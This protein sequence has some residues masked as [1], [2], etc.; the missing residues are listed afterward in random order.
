MS[1]LGSRRQCSSPGL[2]AHRRG[3]I[4]QHHDF[5]WGVGRC[6]AEVAPPFPHAVFGLPG[7]DFSTACQPLRQCPSHRDLPPYRAPVWASSTGVPPACLVPKSSVCTCTALFIS[8]WLP[9]DCGRWAPGH[10]LWREPNASQ[11]ACFWRIRCVV[12]CFSRKEE[13]PLPPGRSGPDLVARLLELEAFASAFESLGSSTSSDPLG[14]FLAK[15]PFDLA[16]PLFS[17]RLALAWARA[18]L[19]APPLCTDLWTTFACVLLTVPSFAWTFWPFDSSLG[20]PGEGWVSFRVWGWVWGFCL[21]TRAMA[22][23]APKTP[24]D[25]RRAETRAPLQ[26]FADRVVRP[27][28]RANREKL[29]E[30]FERWLL[31]HGRATVKTMLQWPLD[32]TEEI[33]YILVEYGRS[34][35]RTGAAYYRYSETINAIASARPGI[36]RHLGAAWDPAF[37]WLSE[38]PHAH[39]RALPKGALLALLAA[40]LTWGWLREAAIFGLAWAG[41]LRIGEALG[42]RRRDLILPRDATPGTDYALLQIATPKTRG[43][44][45]KHQAAPL[46]PPDIIRLLDIAFGELPRGAKL[47]PL[48]PSDAASRPSR[49]GL[50]CAPLAAEH[51]STWP[52]SDR[53]E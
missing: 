27:T 33:S 53:E 36:R 34:L 28:T 9:H 4:L 41:L 25:A 1:Y 47:W 46:D 37:P 3:K 26:L 6:L 12:A 49:R 42:A 23:A 32:R 22:P 43:R 13:F 19:Q 2:T 10:L 18:L 29:L 21:C 20:F 14:P 11:K 7:H 15:L 44:A 16:W 51:I 45:A 52:R 8:L 24:A 50:A 31:E 48:S 40:S 17:C 38:E 35:F 39:H 30:D 5:F